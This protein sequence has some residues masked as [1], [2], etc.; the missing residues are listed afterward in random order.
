MIRSVRKVVV[1]G[2]FDPNLPQ[3]PF[4]GNGLMICGVYVEMTLSSCRVSGLLIAAVALLTVAC[5]PPK[6]SPTGMQVRL[7]RPCNYPPDEIHDRWDVVVRY[8]PGG[9]LLLDG[10]A[11][12]DENSLR[13]GVAG[14][15]SPRTRKLLWIQADR[16][17]SYGEVISLMSDLAKDTPSAEM[18]MTTE[19]QTGPVDPDQARAVGAD[20]RSFRTTDFFCVN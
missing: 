18:V 16:R 5:T 10:V 1:C 12:K 3:F 7:A 4:P 2:S 8:L 19:A 9:K 11:F 20:P 14:E 13:N 17:V 6:A 15:L